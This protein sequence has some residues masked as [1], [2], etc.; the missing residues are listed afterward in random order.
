MTLLTAAALAA[1]ATAPS[2]DVQKFR[3]SLDGRAGLGLDDALLGQDGTFVARALVQYVNDPLVWRPES[4]GEEMAAVSDLLGIDALASVT[5][6]A[7]RAGV[8][9]PFYPVT[10][11]DAVAG[12]ATLGDLG[13]DVKYVVIDPEGAPFGLAA[14]GRVEVPTAA[15]GTGIGDGGANWDLGLAASKDV[16]RWLLAANLGVRGAPAVAADNVDWGS[17]LA[18]RLGVARAI[19]S[20]GGVTGE[21]DAGSAFGDFLGDPSASPVEGLVGG[22]LR[23]TPTTA[24]RGAVGTGL[25]QG[26][27][28]PDARILVG[29]GYEPPLSRDADRDGIRDRDDR[30]RTLPED[31]DGFEDQDGCPDPDDDQDGI[32]DE[33][34]LCPR[35]AEDRDG[36]E[37]ENGCPDPLTILRLHIRDEAGRR[38]DKAVVMWDDRADAGADVQREVADGDVGFQVRAAGY[39]DLTDTMRIVNGPPVDLTVTLT[40]LPPPKPTAEQRV[41]ITEEKIEFWDK[42]YF[43]TA[44]TTIKKQSF[45]LLGEIADAMKAHP[46]LKRVRVEGHTD[47]RGKDAANLKLS[48]GRAEAVRAWLVKAGV[49]ADRLVAQG[50][51]EASPV[52][53][54]HTEAAWEKNRR[55]EFVI[56]ERSGG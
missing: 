54:G 37:D 51:G 34:D 28:A 36:N 32:L 3:P 50:F 53:P 55:V 27:G 31:K 48:Q 33:D 25:S 52:D 45:G 47:E 41:V 29:F 40:A 1:P 39:I 21:L 13:I 19:G 56:E 11:G 15:E 16:G 22:W 38:I 46:E 35:E 2:V 4:G 9:V 7:L 17:G 24:L 14:A 43:D 5:W 10:A 6:R 44:R 49:A 30:C 18:L 23:P 42:I 12:G 8:D 26:L 20:K